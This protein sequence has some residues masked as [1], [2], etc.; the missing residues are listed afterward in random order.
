MHKAARRAHPSN[1]AA[2]G[3]RR[4][5]GPAVAGRVAFRAA[6][7]HRPAM[8]TRSRS[9]GDL[10]RG[11]SPAQVAV[12]QQH[13]GAPANGAGTPSGIG[14]KLLLEAP[15]TPGSPWALPPPATPGTTP[16][17]SARQRD[18]GASSAKW[19]GADHALGA[20]AQRCAAAGAG[21]AVDGG[22]GAAAQRPALLGGE[23][24]ERVLT[25][26]EGVT[27]VRPPL[28]WAEAPSSVLQ[29]GTL[30]LTSFRLLFVP[31]DGDARP[32][33]MP[34]TCVLRLSHKA[35]ALHALGGA[36][37]PALKL[38]GLDG[39]RVL[40]FLFGGGAQ[41]ERAAQHNEWHDSD[42]IAALRQSC[43]AFEEALQQKL[44]AQLGFG[45]SFAHHYRGD[46]RVAAKRWAGYD[47]AAE[48][49]RLGVQR[50]RCWQL[51]E[52]NTSYECCPT[53]P[54][55]L[56]VPR[57]ANRAM[58]CGAAQFRSKGRLPALSWL[59]PTTHAVSTQQSP[60]Q[61]DAGLI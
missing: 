56:A 22:R 10:R 46:Q 37:L 29:S 28:A 30:Y 50:S 24:P 15:R 5:V 14:G 13:G 59:E 55:V 1:I 57:L 3:G 49:E 2:L 11:L 41:L 38:H 8:R 31:A 48:L 36:A 23:P 42:R 19:G 53:Y 7:D 9:T 60:P 40:R 18:G 4:R 39:G 47:A 16:S 51:W 35:K 25:E 17:V 27:L 21:E 20:F 12:L 33:D 52:G 58:V 32:T 45:V 26:A 6:R 44:K 61:F 43:A 54:A 34:L